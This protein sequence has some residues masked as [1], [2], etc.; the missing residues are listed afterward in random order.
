MFRNDLFKGKRILIT[1]G[2]TGLGKAMARRLMELGAELLA[3]RT[4]G[5]R[6]GI[7]TFKLPGHDANDIRRKLESANI[8]VRCRAG[9]VRISPHGYATTDEVDRLIDVLRQIMRARA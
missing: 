7:V 4:A 1:G 2:G 9:G 8:I 6:S 3:P 5:H